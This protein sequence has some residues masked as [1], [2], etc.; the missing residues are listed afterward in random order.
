MSF[1]SQDE[2][3]G[4]GFR[5]LGRAVRLSR[6]AS[7]YKPENIE[8]GDFSRIDDF[9][10]LSAGPGGI[11]IGKHVHIAVFCSLIG[12][13]RIDLSDYSNL[14]SRVAIYSSND[15]YTGEFMTNPT[16][17][18]QFTNVTHAPVSVGKHVII[19]A[20]SIVL[21]G[22]TLHQGA[23]IGALSLVK[24]D[25]QS[26]SIYAGSPARQVGKRSMKLLELETELAAEENKG[27][28]KDRS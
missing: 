7:I 16:V 2:L 6:K 22:V 5:K 25:C 27:E 20:G 4:L 23:G 19:G 28:R 3:L 10:V 8:I 12:S 26:F 9:C 14:S 17:P 24:Q 13:G 11:F 1:Y 18:S 21:P 15:D